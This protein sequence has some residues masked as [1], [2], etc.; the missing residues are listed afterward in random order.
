[1]LILN[2]DNF[3]T[4]LAEAKGAVLV[5]F[6]AEWCG[7]CKMMTPVLEKLESE[8]DDIT[9]AKVNVDEAPELAIKYNVMSIPA[10]LLF[11]DGEVSARTVGYMSTEELVSELGI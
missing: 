3:E 11:N 5:D 1:M 9:I 4:C 7:P 8:R 10:F 2:N 6:W